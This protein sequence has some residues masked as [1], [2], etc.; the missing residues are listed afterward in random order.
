M[1]T[2]GYI[3][4]LLS[5]EAVTQFFDDST[6]HFAHVNT[7]EKCLFSPISVYCSAGLHYAFYNIAVSEGF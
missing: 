3:G 7:G 6:H 4:K 1:I 5:N 2:I